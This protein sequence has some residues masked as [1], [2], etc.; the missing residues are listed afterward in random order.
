M[1]LYGGRNMRA[2]PFIFMIFALTAALVSAETEL[3]HRG[4]NGFGFRS[5]TRDDRDSLNLSDTRGILV[6]TVLEDSPA[7]RAGLQTGDI[8]LKYADSLVL[9]NRQFQNIFPLF[10]AGDTIPIVL[11]RAGEEMTTN[12]ILQAPPLEQSEEI[13][14]EYT[15]FASNGIRL[16]CVVTSPL[17]TRGK[18]LPALFL[19]SALSSPRF[20]D[21]PFYGMIKELAYWVT[22]QGF[23]VMRFELRGYGDSE[24]EDYRLTDFDTEVRDNLAALD[25]L[26]N[27]T[28]V[29]RKDVYVYGHSTAGIIAPVLATTRDIAGLIV[30]CTIGRTYYE[31]MLS[32]LRLQSRFQNESPVETDRTLK[33]YLQLTTLVAGGSSLTEILKAHPDLKE[34][35]NAN[36]RIMDDR[37]AAYWKQQLNINIPDVY[38]QITAPVLIVYA[39]SDYLTEPACHEH[40]RDVLLAAGNVD[41]VLTVIPE[42]DHAYAYAADRK[43]SFD[44][45]QTRNFKEN[46]EV[47][48]AIAAWLV[49]TYGAKDQ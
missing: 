26:M 34:L 35:V 12:I 36:N 10:Y 46:P 47:K 15:S 3:K 1:P 33:A 37:T 13:E 28:D 22:K 27:R 31:R 18:K 4:F 20:I 29:D 21:V 2:I 41:V 45:Y 43:E 7:E 44:N 32:T 6:T 49:S 17:N 48:K 16:R 40:I 14:V 23:R 8:I 19:V 39:A 25:F 24:G 9:D 5:L 11:L 42:A 38:A 30:S